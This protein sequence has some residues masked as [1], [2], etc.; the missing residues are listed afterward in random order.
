MRFLIVEVCFPLMQPTAQSSLS[1]TSL[2]TSN[3][4]T[5]DGYLQVHEQ[6]LLNI[7]VIPP[8]VSAFVFLLLLHLDEERNLVLFSCVEYFLVLFGS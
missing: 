6:L 8:E 7:S 5:L 3:S 2:T 1:F 4:D